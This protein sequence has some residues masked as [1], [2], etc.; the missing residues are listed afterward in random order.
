MAVTGEAIGS[1]SSVSDMI[2]DLPA[3]LVPTFLDYFP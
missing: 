2:A 3:A 1:S